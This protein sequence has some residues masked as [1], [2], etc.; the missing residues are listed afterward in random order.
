MIDEIIDAFGAD[1]IHLGMD[2]IFLIGHPKSPS[3]VGKNPAKLLAIAINEYHDH[4]VK[5]KKLQM[6]MW[7]VS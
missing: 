2:E 1:G 6:F 3:T 7:G 4:F 5:E